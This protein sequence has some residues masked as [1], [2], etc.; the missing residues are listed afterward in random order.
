MRLLLFFGLFFFS[1]LAANSFFATEEN[2]TLAQKEQ[3]VLYLTYEHIPKRVIQGEVFSVTLKTLSTV[4]NYIDVTYTLA[5]AQGLEVLSE[6]PERRESTKYLYDTFYF[7]AKEKDARLPSFEAK[8]LTDTYD[9]YKTTTLAGEGLNIISLNPRRNFSHVI[10]NSFELME[11]KTSSYDSEHN[12]VIFVARAFNSDLSSIKL[13]GIEKQGIESISG[14]H[15]ESRVTYYA[16]ID[17]KMEELSFSYFNLHTNNFLQVTIPIIV[18]ED[19]VVTQTDLKPTDQS[20]EQ[21][22]RAHV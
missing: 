14:D 19:T 21:I 2:A 12:I 15:V 6:V 16:V 18:E 10:A 22:G 7:I 20:K 5:D 17:K 11:Y 8:L 9:T 4:R 13:G 3:K 1:S